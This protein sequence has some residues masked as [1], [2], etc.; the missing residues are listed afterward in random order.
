MNYLR[1]N[2]VLNPLYSGYKECY[3]FQSFSLMKTA[4][5]LKSFGYVRF[6]REQYKKRLAYVYVLFLISR[7]K[8]N[9][10]LLCMNCYLLQET[11]LLFVLI[12]L[13]QICHLN[14]YQK[15]TNFFSVEN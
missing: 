1:P 12:E 11:F 6:C 4:F 15:V 13:D 14:V 9:K 10:N 7:C 8:L 3:L 5:N 2:V